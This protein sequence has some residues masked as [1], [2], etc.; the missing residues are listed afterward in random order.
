VYRFFKRFFDVLVSG[1]A[2]VILTP[3]L[4]PVMLALRLTGEGEVFY[5]QQR[6]GYKNTTF[7][8]WKFATMLRDSPNLGTGSLTV[9]GDPRVTR[10]GRSLRATKVNELPQLINVLT[11]DMSFVGPRPQVQ[12]DY[13]GYPPHVREHIYDVPP[14]VTGIG[15]IV[16]RDEERLLSKPGIDPR[17]F[18]RDEIAPF[19]GEL[20]MWYLE[21]RSLWLDA[22]LMALTVWVVLRPSS[23]IVYRTFRDLPARPAW[24][25]D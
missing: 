17:A 14:G 9:R 1:V 8:I 20:E 24:L 6:I 2:V 16:F 7:G 12:V 5:R 3:L 15:S 18:Y 22:R 23:D 11:G 13:D 19:K 21:H 10:V 4:S 25:T